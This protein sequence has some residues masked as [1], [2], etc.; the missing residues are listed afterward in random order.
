M[1]VGL[2]IQRL[3]IIPFQLIF[4]RCSHNIGQGCDKIY[5]LQ[6]GISEGKISKPVLVNFTLV[7][8]CWFS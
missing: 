5:N 7:F 1:V 8:Y 3:K 6:I 2:L 4:Q